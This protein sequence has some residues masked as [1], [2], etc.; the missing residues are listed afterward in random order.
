MLA[1]P[2]ANLEL[3]WVDLKTVQDK[4]Q[5]LGKTLYHQG[6]LSYFEAVNKEALKNAYGRSQEEGIF[7]ISRPGKDAKDGPRIRLDA[8]WMPARGAEGEVKP[9]GKLWEYCERIS[10]SRREGKNRRDGATVRTRVLGLV[11]KVGKDLFVSTVM[12]DGGDL[13]VFRS[14]QQ[15]VRTVAQL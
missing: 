12:G 11:D 13:P 15:G 5:L 6:D 2:S 4:A 9:E 1:P 3:Q 7:Q 8:R 10:Q 14:R